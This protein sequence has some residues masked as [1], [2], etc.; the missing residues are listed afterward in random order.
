[1][2]LQVSI[3]NAHLFIEMSFI[4]F[5]S[6]SFTLLLGADLL[7]KSD[8]K[9]G[10]TW[11]S[12]RSKKNKSDLGLK[13][14]EIFSKEGHLTFDVPTD[15]EVEICIRASTASSKN[16]LRFGLK[17]EESAPNID[18]DASWNDGVSK[19]WTQMEEE[20]RL[21][22]RTMKAIQ[23]EADY[24]KDRDATFHKQTLDMYAASMYWPIVHVCVLLLTG[25]TQATHIVR[26][27]KSR[28]IV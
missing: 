4:R 7:D 24:S 26:F 19:Q 23:A 27:F 20:I 18:D 3:V 1:M 10:P 28:H 8:H 14:E 11:I 5:P 21:S 6:H 25:F 16:P 15:G 12:V 22:M 2:K 17:V 9:H 13:T